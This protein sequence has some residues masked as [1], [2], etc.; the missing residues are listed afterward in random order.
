MNHGTILWPRR[1]RHSITQPLR[2]PTPGEACCIDMMDLSGTG[3][4]DNPIPPSIFDTEANCKKGQRG[5]RQM[6]LPDDIATLIMLRRSYDAKVV[7][8]AAVPVCG[9]Q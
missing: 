9:D 8:G 6:A 1:R 7:H 2:L 5:F 4:R 3:V